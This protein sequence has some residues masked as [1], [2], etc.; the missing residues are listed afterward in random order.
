[1]QYYFNALLPNKS[2]FFYR[3]EVLMGRAIGKLRMKTAKKTDE[4]VRYTEETISGMRVIKLYAWEELFVKFANLSRRQVNLK[5]ISFKKV[6]I[7]FSVKIS[8]SLFIY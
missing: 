6:I 1:M 8:L 2:T 7:M 4:R 5:F 3:F